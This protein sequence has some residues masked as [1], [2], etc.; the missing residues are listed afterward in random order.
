MTLLSFLAGEMSAAFEIIEATDR[1]ANAGGAAVKLPL[2][3]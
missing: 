3:R 1:S 2:G